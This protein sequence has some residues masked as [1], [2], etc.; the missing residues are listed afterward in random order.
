MTKGENIK[1]YRK[2][3]G[4]T[5]KELGQLCGIAETTIRR[6]ELG[7]LNPKYETLEKIAKALDIEVSDLIPLSPFQY[8]ESLYDERYKINTFLEKIESLGYTINRLEN[9]EQNTIN[10]YSKNGKQYISLDEEKLF[11]IMK[12]IDKYLLFQLEQLFKNNGNENVDISNS[13]IKPPF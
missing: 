13:D 11:S 6:Y 7:S 9:N 2:K 12:E 4:L 1:K 8:K 3:R 10:I 5:Q